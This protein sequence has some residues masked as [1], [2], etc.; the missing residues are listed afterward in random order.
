MKS[1]F[2]LRVALL[3][4]VA[5]AL[6]PF[7][8]AGVVAPNGDATTE[9][10]SNNVWPF[11]AGW[12]GTNSTSRDQQVY[13]ASQFGAS[14]STLNIGAIAFRFDS[15]VN[16]QTETDFF[17]NIEIDLSTTVVSADHMSTAFGKNIGADDTVVYSGPLTLTGTALGQSPNPFN[18]IINLQTPFLYNTARG[19]L[20]LDIKINAPGS[21]P[22]SA[23]DADSTLGD[24]T[25]RLWSSTTGSVNDIIGNADTFGLVTEFL[26][27]TGA[28]EPSTLALGGLALVGA[29]LLRTRTRRP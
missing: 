5:G 21:F 13:N 29:G 20:L 26:P 6:A 16:P 3:V 14:G 8:G 23:L 17:P 22:I 12:F 7:A 28:P 1:I 11:S 25:S 10:N 15:A 18:L 24:G 2:V 4:V 9:G 27:P 19:N